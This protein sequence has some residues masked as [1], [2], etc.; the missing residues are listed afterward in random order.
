M[1]L[2]QEDVKLARG[3][4][5]VLSGCTTPLGQVRQEGRVG[6]ARVFMLAEARL[7]VASSRCAPSTS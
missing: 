1:L 5:V 6:L 3:A 4:T 2:L 7:V